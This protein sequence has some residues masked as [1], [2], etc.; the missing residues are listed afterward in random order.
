M[1]RSRLE[2]ERRW[3]RGLRR[4]RQEQHR[5]CERLLDNLDLNI[6]TCNLPAAAALFMQSD[7]KSDDQSNQ[8]SNRNRRHDKEAP[9]STSPRDVCVIPQILEFLPFRTPD[10]P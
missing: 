3:V 8:A 9:P 4:A 7:D 2:K 1:Y 6:F 5:C 10:I